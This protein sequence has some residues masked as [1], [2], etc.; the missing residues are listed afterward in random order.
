VS[1]AGPRA[2]A[3]AF[4]IF[5]VTGDLTQRKLL[6]ALY[7]L[8]LKGSLHPDS[9]IIGH[10]RSDLTVEDLRKRLREAVEREVPEFDEDA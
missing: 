6:P 5:G 9:A 1:P 7:R 4:V 10:A 8:H 2:P 3:C